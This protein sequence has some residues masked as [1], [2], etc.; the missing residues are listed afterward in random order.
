MDV[1]QVENLV[2]TFG[3]FT[4]VNNITFTVKR[5]EAFGLLGPN[6]A[7]KSTTIQILST[8][9]RPT[10]GRAIIAGYDVIRHQVQVRRSIGL[11]FQGPSLDDRLTAAENL[12]FH[13]LLY[14]IPRH[15]IKKRIDELLQLVGLADR[16]NSVV[17]TFSGGMRRRLEIARGI[18]HQPS[19][20]FLDEPTVGLDPQTRNAIW[21]YITELKRQRE[22]TIFMTTHYMEEAE[23]CDRI[24]I[25]DNGVIVALD[26][27][28]RLKQKVGGDVI[29]I[30]SPNP[31]QLKVEIRKRYQIEAQEIK[32][33]LRL[34]VSNGASLIPSLAADF[35]GL[36]S[37]INLRQPTLDD[38]FLKLTGRAIRDEEVNARDAMRL[39]SARWSRGR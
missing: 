6:G 23:N 18:L 15:L 34:E 8:L 2:K 27:P 24:A 22:I 16:R 30:H 11:V 25:I 17:R 37:S 32:D 21:E 12:Y 36:I 14:N 35:R 39:R 5:G 1:V 33:G 7:G 13:A 10:S 28:E 20:L 38:V 29:T 4:A 9:L 26:T 3:R 19:V 31:N